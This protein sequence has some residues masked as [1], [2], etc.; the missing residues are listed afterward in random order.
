MK[1]RSTLVRAMSVVIGL[2]AVAL[3]VAACSTNSSSSTSTTSG[4]SGSSSTPTGS[5]ITIGGFDSLSNPEYSAPETQSGLQAAVGDI[6]AHGGINGHVLKLNFCNSGYIA[7][8]ELACTN[9]LIAANVT[10]LVAP[11]ILADQ[12]GREYTAAQAAGMPIIGTQG[13]TPPELTSPVTFPAGSGIP[14]WAYG[15]ADALVSQGIR[16]INILT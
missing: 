7:N 15:A 16:K 4:G 14:G 5:P 8:Q 6:N 12:T 2:V 11:S 3:V 9:Q 10:A 13:L 1:S